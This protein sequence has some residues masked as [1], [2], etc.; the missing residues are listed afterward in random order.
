MGEVMKREVV[1]HPGH[2]C[3]YDVCKLKPPCQTKAPGNHQA[4]DGRNHG[5]GGERWYYV[6]TSDDRRHAVVLAVHTDL[7]PPTVPDDHENRCGTVPPGVRAPRDRTTPDR[8]VAHVA[9]DRDGQ[10]CEFVAGGK[11]H[12]FD[13]TGYHEAERIWKEYGDPTRAE[14]Q[15]EGLWR[16]LEVQ[17]DRV[18]TETTV[19][20]DPKAPHLVAEA[21]RGRPCKQ[22]GIERLVAATHTIVERNFVS[23]EVREVFLCCEHAREIFGGDCEVKAGDI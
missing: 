21:C 15:S 4:T 16:A 8:I 12:G 22:C 18:I 9:V 5:I 17:L 14:P 2:D 1:K 3:I 10:T 23:G 7:F 20:P 11:C 13:A 19:I 6:V